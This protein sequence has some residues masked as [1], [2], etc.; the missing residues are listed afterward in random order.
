M[1]S[2]RPFSAITSRSACRQKAVSS[3]WDRLQ[4][5]TLRPKL[6]GAALGNW[7]FHCDTWTDVVAA[8]DLTERFL[9]TQGL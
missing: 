1:M 2:S 5:S 8:R 4:A 7:L 9:L 3:E 6:A